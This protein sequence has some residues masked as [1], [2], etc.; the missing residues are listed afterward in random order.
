MK[1]QLLCLFA[2]AAMLACVPLSSAN[3]IGGGGGGHGRGGH[4]G[5]GHGFGG[6]RGFGGGFGG[7]VIGFGGGDFGYGGWDVAELYRELY[8]NLPY[9]ALHPPVYYSEPVPRTYGYSPFAYPPGT[10]T[11][12]IVGEAQPVTINNPYAPATTPA[13]AEVKPSD[14]SASASPAPEPLV[15]VNP[16]VSPAGSVAKGG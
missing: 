15:I 6:G 16:F 2:L 10:M 1:R 3:A 5:G 9:F 7:G 12:E 14:R 13:K 11:P 8:N 4:G